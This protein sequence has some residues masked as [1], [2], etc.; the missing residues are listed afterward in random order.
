MNILQEVEDGIDSLGSDIKTVLEDAEPAAIELWNDAKSVFS[1]ME[2]VGLSQLKT[3]TQS[4]LAGVATAIA[5]GGNLGAAV[6]AAASS[7]FSQL[8]ADVTADAKNALYTYL[9][10]QIA[11]LQ[12]AGASSGNGAAAAKA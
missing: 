10:L 2:A 7:A 8:G 1:Q 12:A 11:K 4:G 9:G 3:I 6:S 5:T